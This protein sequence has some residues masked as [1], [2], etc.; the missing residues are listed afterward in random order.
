[1]RT[2]YL[3]TGWHIPTITDRAM[4]T[5]SSLFKIINVE[6]Q[7]IK[8]TPFYGFERSSSLKSTYQ[9]VFAKTL[10]ETEFY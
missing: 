5:V 8:R 4:D 10:N 6:S 1:M 7:K 3:L 9:V 2:Y